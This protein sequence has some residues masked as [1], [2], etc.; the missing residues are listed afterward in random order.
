MWQD[1]GTPMD[2]DP[3]EGDW[4]SFEEWVVVGDAE[5]CA[6]LAHYAEL[7]VSDLMLHVAMRHIEPSAVTEAIRGFAALRNDASRPVAVPER[8]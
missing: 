1:I 7:G 5:H 2:L 4:A 8:P 3:S 6:M